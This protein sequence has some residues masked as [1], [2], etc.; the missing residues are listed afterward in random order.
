VR[1]SRRVETFS[2][3]V[4]ELFPIKPIGE[5]TQYVNRLKAQRHE[6]ETAVVRE[7]IEAGYDEAVRRLHARYR[8]G[9]MTFR[10]VAAE[11][12]LSVRDL[13]A[14]FEQKGLPT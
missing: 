12:G 8:R 2:E 10:T 1:H 11:L 6:T 4:R 3:I 7:L 13:Y 9:E 14:L 5:I